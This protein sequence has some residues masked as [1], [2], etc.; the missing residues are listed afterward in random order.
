MDDQLTLRVK[1]AL[2]EVPVANE[3]VSRWLAHRN[4]PPAADYFAKLAIEELVT[5]CIKYAYDDTNEHFIEIELK[6]SADDLTLTVTDDGHPF[7]PLELPPPNTNLPLEERP[8]GGLGIHL[9]R[10]SSDRMEYARVESKNQ[11]MLRKS[12]GGRTIHRDQFNS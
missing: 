8:I 9:L 3:A 1:N 11:L 7:N 6:L 12:L 2:A 5:N 4:A 10:E